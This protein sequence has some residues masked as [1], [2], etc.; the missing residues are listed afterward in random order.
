MFDLGSNGTIFPDT[1]GNE[2]TIKEYGIY[3]QTAKRVSDWLPLNKLIKFIENFDGQ[4]L[5]VCESEGRQSVLTDLLSTHQL[6]VNDCSNWSDFHNQNN[7]LCITNASLSEGVLF[8]RIAII[9]ENNLF[10]KDAVVD[11][12][13]AVMVLDRYTEFNPVKPEQVKTF[14]VGYKSVINNKLVIDMAYF[15][16]IYTNF[17]TNELVVDSTKGCSIR[18]LRHRWPP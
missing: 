3:A 17:I 14:E 11:S 7:G 8:E 5:I 18:G 16:N 1:V 4:V 12:A 2:I 15:Y 6:K 9:T 10:G 13:D